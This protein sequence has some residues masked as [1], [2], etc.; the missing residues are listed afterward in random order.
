MRLLGPLAW[1]AC[2]GCAAGRFE[3]DVYRGPQVAF[4]IGALGPEWRRIDLAGGDVVLRHRSGGT[5]VANGSCQGLG[6]LPL[7]VLANQ[8]LF[9]VNDIREH[10]RE[11]LTLD[12]RAALR[13]RLTGTVDGV[14]IDLDLVVLKKDGCVYD[15]Q[16][17]APPAAFA[18][19]D[20]DFD[21]LVAG[22]HALA[23]PR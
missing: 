17:A 22:F 8:A 6:D 13:L 11:T 12:G 10:G 3:G 5:V 18:E 15:L 4:R 23:V 21:R 19:R 9:G 14:P 7:Q 1:I 16:L 20:Q 2:L